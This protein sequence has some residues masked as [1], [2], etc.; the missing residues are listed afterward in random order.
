[1]Q[2]KAESKVNEEKLRLVVKKMALWVETP[3]ST[4]SQSS[5]EQW[6]QAAPQGKWKEISLCVVGVEDVVQRQKKT[7]G[8]KAAEKVQSG[9][10]KCSFL[11]KK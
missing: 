9:R 8:I 5:Q 6:A 4:E 2:T 1:M 10:R 3:V 7:R 11:L